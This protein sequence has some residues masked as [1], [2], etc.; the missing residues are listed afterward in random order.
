[1]KSGAPLCAAL[2][3]TALACEEGRMTTV[4]E[5]RRELVEGMSAADV[6]RFFAVHRI[7]HSVLRGA[8]LLSE[9]DL[10]TPQNREGIHSRYVAIIR[11]VAVRWAIYS[12]SIQIKVDMDERG[13]AR[14]VDVYRVYTGP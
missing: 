8:Q 11:G 1:M 4:E 6:E 2:L 5:V 10:Q 9:S 7:E 3:F 13:K 14:R 12:E